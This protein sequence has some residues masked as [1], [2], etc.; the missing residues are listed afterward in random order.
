MGSWALPGNCL[1]KRVE[2]DG[3]KPRAEGS[4]Q[5]RL[6]PHGAADWPSGT[7]DMVQLPDGHPLTR[8]PWGNERIPLISTFL[9]LNGDG[10]SME[11]LGCHQ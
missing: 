3:T 7:G 5:D 2:G 11:L 4:S 6:L 8:G 1:E 10:Y 9:L